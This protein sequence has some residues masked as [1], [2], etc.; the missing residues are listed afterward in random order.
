MQKQLEILHSFVFLEMKCVLW[1]YLVTLLLYYLFK[2][3]SYE[4]E[5]VS[6]RLVVLVFASLDM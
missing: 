4:K 6:A 5:I 2:M 3:A 1:V